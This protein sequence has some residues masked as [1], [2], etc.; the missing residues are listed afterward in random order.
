MTGGQPDPIDVA[1]AALT[2]AARP[3]DPD[4]G[5][6]READMGEILCRVATAVAA[7]LGSEE[8]LLAGRPGSWEAALIRQVVESTAGEHLAV[9]RTVPVRLLLDPEEVFNDL[10]LWALYD[11]AMDELN[12]LDQA[13]ATDENGVMTEAG[14]AEIDAVNAAC[15]AVETLWRADLDAFVASFTAAARAAAAA[16]GLTVGVQVQRVDVDAG[17]APLHDLAEALYAAAFEQAV[18]PSGLRRIDYPAGT[19]PGDI[20][21]EAGRGY[22]ARTTPTP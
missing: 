9:Y 19:R 1:I 4:T 10:G 16:R 3:V 11:E 22:L 2:A 15:V 21:R 8:A 18:L 14:E 17:P 6:V 20:D 5:E 7:N 13:V 12:D